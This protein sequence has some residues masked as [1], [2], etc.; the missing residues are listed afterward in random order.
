MDTTAAHPL[1]LAYISK[2]LNTDEKARAYIESVRW[3]DGPVCPH[4]GVVNE[5]TRFDG[6][7]GAKGTKARPGTWKCNACKSQF[8]VTVG[9]VMQDTRLGLELWLLAMHQISANKKGISALSLSRMLGVSPKT[10]WH[11]C[12]RIRAAMAD[13]STEPLDGIVEADETFIGGKAK[14]AHKNK[15]IPPKTPVVALVQRNGKVKARAVTNV[16]ETNIGPMLSGMIS[17]GA[18]LMTDDARVYIKPG[19][20]FAAHHSVNHSAGEYVRK[21]GDIKAHTNTVESFN[22]LVKRN[23]VGAYHAISDRHI[24][25]YLDE[26]S[27]RWNTRKDTDGE[28]TDAIIA[29]TEGKHLPLHPLKSAVA[30]GELR[31]AL[32]EPAT[33]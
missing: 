5:A 19:A 20:E 29:N 30:A 31:G 28:R 16:D 26:V 21:E 25:R 2:H 33:E 6:K 24:G 7:G 12:H 10:A 1:T 15:P 22:A 17:E 32:L 14:N 23:I 4:C 13:A 27:M 8:S 3:P 11:L 18:I 9:T